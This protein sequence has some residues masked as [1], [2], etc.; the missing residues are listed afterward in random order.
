[1]AD[2]IEEV[3]EELKRERHLELWRKYG[4]FVIAGALL[5][6]IA[7]AAAVGWRQYRHN[8]LVETGLAYAEAT[9][10]MAAGKTDQALAAFRSVGEEGTTGYA[11]LARFQEAALLARQGDEAG[12]GRVYE[13][14]AADSAAPKPFRDLALILYALNAADRAD[15]AQL[16]ARLDPLTAKE[17][18]W[19]FSALEITALLER[20]RGDSNAAHIIY[21]QLADDPATPPRMRAR[22]AE[23]LAILES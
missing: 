9:D 22:A 11:T 23:M 17:S 16:I 7:V 13:A 1:M 19:R 3:E 6:V 21:K 10:L 8:R 4:R 5:L 2:F 18:P 20:R 14:I 12:A 15:P